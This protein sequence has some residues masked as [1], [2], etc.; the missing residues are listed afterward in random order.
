MAQQP[1]TDLLTKSDLF[2]P[3][4]P[5]V[6]LDSYHF[7]RAATAVLAAAGDANVLQLEIFDGE[8]ILL[9]GTNQTDL[10]RAWVPLSEPGGSWAHTAE[11]AGTGPGVDEKPD[12]IVCAGLDTLAVRLLAELGKAK[13]GKDYPAEIVCVEWGHLTEG[14]LTLGGPDAPP[15]VR[16]VTGTAI[17][18]ATDTGK[19]FDWRP[20]ATDIESSSSRVRDGLGTTISGDWAITFG[21]LGNALGTDRH[22]NIDTA[23]VEGRYYTVVR[24]PGFPAVRGFGIDD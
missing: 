10:L 11:V 6:D 21:K 14:Q 16:I 24:I 5:G 8:G 13:R 15:A 23:E 3:D 9:V 20:Y 1:E 2:R 4:A 7:A 18:I 22:I 12:R 19:P 17:S